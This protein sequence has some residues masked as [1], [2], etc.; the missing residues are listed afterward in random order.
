MRGLDKIPRGRKDDSSVL[1][2]EN[3]IDKTRMK[4]IISEY[5]RGITSI[6]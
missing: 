3:D 5:K 6:E 4:T 1:F 2:L